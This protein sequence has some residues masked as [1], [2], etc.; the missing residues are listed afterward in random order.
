MRTD[1]GTA[2]PDE[3]V[4]L[5]FERLRDGKCPILPVIQNNHLIG[6]LTAENVAELVTIREAV[7]SRKMPTLPLSAGQGSDLRLLEK[8]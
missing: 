8:N 7:R 1:F 5:V 4:E 6:L 3:M 2:E